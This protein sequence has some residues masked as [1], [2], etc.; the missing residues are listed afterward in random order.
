MTSSK[1]IFEYDGETV[2]I[3]LS[4]VKFCPGPCNNTMDEPEPSK[5]ASVYNRREDTYWFKPYSG[6]KYM[7]FC[8]PITPTEKKNE[9][10]LFIFI[11]LKTM[12]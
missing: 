6:G 9:T 7:R 12:F 10:R 2:S 3:D 11:Y 5:Y 1:Q 8:F 4:N